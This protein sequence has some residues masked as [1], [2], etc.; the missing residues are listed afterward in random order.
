MTSKRTILHFLTM[1]VIAAAG[2]GGSTDTGTGASHDGGADDAASGTGGGRVDS[3]ADTAGGGGADS[4]SAGSGGDANTGDAKTSD[5]DAD[6]DANN[7]TDA[8]A[9]ADVA[10]GDSGS[11]D[12]CFTLYDLHWGMNGGLTAYDDMSRLGPCR[13]YSHERTMNIADAASLMC[14]ATVPGCPARTIQEIDNAIRDPAVQ[15]ALQNHTLYGNDP[16]P[17][18]GQV[19]RI[20]VGNDFIDVGPNCDTTPP[21][22]GMPAALATLVADLHSLDSAELAEEP[23]R[24]VFGN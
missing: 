14:T 11:C 20:G 24:S 21:C 22:T 19:F 9:N 10:L 12:D 15:T 2:C 16:R 4:G 8:D 6:A 5:A 7:N 1:L 3:G 13:S 17:V 18:D 23:C